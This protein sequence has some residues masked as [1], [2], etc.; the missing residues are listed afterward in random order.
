MSLIV[1]YPVCQSMPVMS[2][3]SSSYAANMLSSYQSFRAASWSYALFSISFI[4][5]LGVPV[6]DGIHC[7]LMMAVGCVKAGYTT[8]KIRRYKDVD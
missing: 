6:L 3:L 5:K 7:A 1:K 2:R 4:R 8:S